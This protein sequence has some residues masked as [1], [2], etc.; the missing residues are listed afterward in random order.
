M[1]ILGIINIAIKRLEECN[2]KYKKDAEEIKEYLLQKKEQFVQK[3][4]KE[5]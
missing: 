2:G 5:E 3:L 4:N 1:P